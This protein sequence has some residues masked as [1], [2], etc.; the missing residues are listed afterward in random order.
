MYIYCTYDILP[1]GLHH[2][3][4]L[5]RVVLATTLIDAFV[6]GVPFAEK[7]HQIFRSFSCNSERLGAGI[8]FYC[9]SLQ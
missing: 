3:H 1:K 9:M 7:K 4:H 2:R 5:T 8:I 6:Q